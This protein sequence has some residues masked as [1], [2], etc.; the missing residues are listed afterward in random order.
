[1]LFYMRQH[2]KKKKKKRNEKIYSYVSFYCAEKRWKKKQDI[3]LPC[4]LY[5][6]KVVSMLKVYFCSSHKIMTTFTQRRS[7]KVTVK[8]WDELCILICFSYMCVVCSKCSPPLLF[9]QTDSN[10]DIV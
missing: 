3:Y 5:V 8:A 7:V 6:C 9:S 1:M 2:A 4:Q 10:S